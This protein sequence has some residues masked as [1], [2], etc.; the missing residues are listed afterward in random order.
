MRAIYRDRDHLCIL[1]GHLSTLSPD[2]LADAVAAVAT[3]HHEDDD[4]VI[5]RIYYNQISHLYIYI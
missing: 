5:N 3:S 1:G 4:E 2:E